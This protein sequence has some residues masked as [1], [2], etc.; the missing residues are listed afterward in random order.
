[1]VTLWDAG[2]AG[3]AAT[4]RAHKSFVYAV[5]FSPDGKT[6]ASAGGDRL[7]KLWE[8][9]T[10]RELNALGVHHASIESLAFSPDGRT[11][12]SGDHFGYIRLWEYG[13]G[14]ALRLLNQEGP[15]ASHLAFSADGKLLASGGDERG[16]VWDVANGRR[17]S[18]FGVKRFILSSLALSPDGLK[19]AAA[20]CIPPRFLNRKCS[21][22]LWD[23]STGRE[24]HSFGVPSEL[25]ALAFSR[26]GKLLAGVG[27]TA[28][29]R[30][31]NTSTGALVGTLEELRGTPHTLAFDDGAKRLT[32]SFDFG[33][34]PGR[35]LWDVD[36]RKLVSPPAFALPPLP[37]LET[38]DPPKPPS[39]PAPPESD[40]IEYGGGGA[41]VG[42]G[43]GSGFG[44]GFGTGR[45]IWQN[46]YPDEPD[47]GGQATGPRVQTPHQGGGGYTPI[48]RASQVTVKARVTHQPEALFTERARR[49]LTTGHV[50]L[51]AVLSPNGKV[52]NIRVIRE[53]PHFLTDEAVR[54]A[55]LIKFVPAIKDG[56]AVP[57]YVTLDYHFNIY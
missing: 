6:L 46:L 48:F 9:G 37:P 35:V 55:R 4:L 10:G 31:W 8:A 33:N 53:L 26:D 23:A 54:A 50:R 12:A 24:L 42:V 29:P 44:P 17:L 32:G 2:P 14:R 52:T 25:E 13:A 18:A 49:N 7:V 56:H 51:R 16:F 19:V 22:R 47:V 21:V 39:T 28:A 30:L 41:V 15:A 38:A 40:G 45:G 1:L 27:S 34:A 11:L 3:R 5:A 57:Q 36:T 43:D 20:G